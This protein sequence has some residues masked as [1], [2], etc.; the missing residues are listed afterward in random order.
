LNRGGK[1]NVHFSI[2]HQSF[3]SFKKHFQPKTDCI[4][5]T[6]TDRAKVAINH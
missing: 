1:K 6:V 5:E 3:Y 2:N 4:S